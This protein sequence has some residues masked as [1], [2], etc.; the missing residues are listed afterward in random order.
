MIFKHALTQ[1]THSNSIRLCSLLFLL[2]ASTPC[3]AQ[4]ANEDGGSEKKEDAKEVVTEMDSAKQ[5][6]FDKLKQKFVLDYASGNYPAVVNVAGRLIRMN[7]HDAQLHF[8]VGQ[9]K[10]HLGGILA[11][12]ISFDKAIRINPEYVQA[13]V[14]RAEVLY[15][16]G[17]YGPSAAD[18]EKAY[19][20]TQQQEFLLKSAKS[21][22][23]MKAPEK[24]LEDIA[25]I[26]DANV[27]GERALAAQAYYDLSKFEEAKGE[28]EYVF[29]NEPENDSVYDLMFEIYAS[30]EDHKSIARIAEEVYIKTD[31]IN[32]L[33]ANANYKIGKLD[34]A[35]ELYEQLIFTKP[36]DIRYNGL[37]QIY[38]DRGERLKAVEAYEKSIGENPYQYEILLLLGNM[39]LEERKYYTAV[40]AYNKAIE[41]NRENYLLYKNKGIALFLLEKYDEARLAFQSALKYE[42]ND[43][44]SGLGLLL[45]LVMEGK[46][47]ETIELDKKVEAAISNDNLFGFA[48]FA[49]YLGMGQNDKALLE[50][51]GIDETQLKTKSPYY[52]AE[53][54]M[55]RSSFKYK[56]ALESINKVPENDTALSNNYFIYDSFVNLQKAE[57]LQNVG[58]YQ[59]AIDAFKNVKNAGDIEQTKIDLNIARSYYLLS[60]F[61]KASYHF[62][63]VIR[64]DPYSIEG[65]TGKAEAY[66]KMRNFKKSQDYIKRA[67]DLEKHSIHLYSV[68]Y[69][70]YMEQGKKNQLKR[71]FNKAKRK[72]RDERQKDFIS[73]V[74]SHLRKKNKAALEALKPLVTEDNTDQ[75]NAFILATIAAISLEEKD[76]TG[77]VEACDRAIEINKNHIEAQYYKA[78]GLYGQGMYKD[79]IEIMTAT[80]ENTRF[81]SAYL[82]RAKSYQRTENTEKACEDFK[83]AGEL[84]NKEAHSTY[85][86]QCN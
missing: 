63:Q 25:K 71:L 68:M 17:N 55:F 83:V 61:E 77:A 74:M 19:K 52:I 53:S 13:L 84:G 58:R 62:D 42:A 76:Y 86:L 1:F 49:A 80:L 23:A 2:L 39:A 75:E 56:E 43:E 3:F 14:A 85:I 34:R 50:L 82:L 38:I 40:N 11:S 47:Q 64:L 28:I 44:L 35:Q 18:Y 16:M 54:I 5:A 29:K 12:M 73:G 51:E 79:A 36:S 65:I 15:Q 48:T 46:Y 33:E 31:R 6:L 59:D 8:F 26:T 66:H 4:E 70:I 69:E 57:A 22:Q 20:I 10:R 60:N 30:L 21:K 72:T 37:A 41:I 45:C 32:N 67:L 81:P 7:R 27:H 9:A 24:A 78:K